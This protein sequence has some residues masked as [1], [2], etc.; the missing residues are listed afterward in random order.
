MRIYNESQWYALPALYSLR[1]AN[2]GLGPLCRELLL[3]LRQVVIIK[4]LKENLT[5]HHLHI[6][7][8]HDM[9]DNASNWA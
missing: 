6:T 7:T 9:F 4:H 8:S 3:M 1:L 5:A 2:L